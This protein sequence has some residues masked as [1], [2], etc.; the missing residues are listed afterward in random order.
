M[1]NNS[2]KMAYRRFCVIL[3]VAAG[4]VLSVSCHRKEAAVELSPVEVAVTVID[5]TASGL[6]RT[7]VGEVEPEESIGLSFAT[8]GKVEQV[9]VRPGDRVVAGQKLVTVSKSTAQSAYN[10][11]KA[12]LDQAEDAYN[13]IKQVHDKGS[14]AEVKWVEMLTTLEKARSMEQIARK[15]LEDCA[16]TAPSA[17][18][19]GECRATAGGSL[20]PGE[21]AVTLLNIRSV[22]VNI[23]VPESEIASVPEGKEVQITV[24]A[25]NNLHLTGRISERGMTASR[26]SHSYTVKIELPN[27]D[28][29]LLPGMVCKVS[30]DE[31]DSRGIVIPAKCVQTR[32]EG[33]SVWVVENGR[34]QHRLLTA[35]QFVANGV[36]VSEGLHPGDTVI[37]AG[38]Q[39]LYTNAE[40]TVHEKP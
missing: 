34:A 9:L 39:K 27:P 38:T 3:V 31:A 35:T 23:S 24:P 1:F 20:L 12:T 30:M 29:Q 16:L 5:T 26:V 8:G 4:L 40:V 14:M 37:T 10:S 7:Y 22:T 32:P 28:Q 2:T 25:L 6:T 17:G 18:V 36:L 19:I 13:R 11:A 15:Q 33:L 21:S